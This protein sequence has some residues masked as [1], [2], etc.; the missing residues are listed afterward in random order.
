MTLDPTALVL[1]ALLLAA[2]TIAAGVAILSARAR[3]RRADAIQ[4][5]A[6]RLSRMIDESPALPML[7]RADGRIEASQ[8]LAHWLGLE[9][10]PDYLSE[11]DAGD[12]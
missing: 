10:V 11:L 7:V 4:R 2:W 8:R 1:I 12:K 9:N 5:N 6:R 3:Q